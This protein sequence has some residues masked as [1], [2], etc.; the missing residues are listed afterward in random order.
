MPC[1]Y[2]LVTYLAR[3]FLI[4]TI[5]PGPAQPMFCSY[6]PVRDVLGLYL[7]PLRTIPH[8][9]GFRNRVTKPTRQRLIQKEAHLACA[10]GTRFRAPLKSSI[11]VMETATRLSQCF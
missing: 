11:G 3:V 1:P 5:L 8:P 10:E 7:L 2:Q 4:H 6:A 9:S